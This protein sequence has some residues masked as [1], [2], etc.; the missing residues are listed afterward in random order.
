MKKNQNQINNLF[1]LIAL[2]VPK[3]SD[4]KS[5]YTSAIFSSVYLQSLDCN[6]LEFSV[7]MNSL[8]LRNVTLVFISEDTK[9]YKNQLMERNIDGNDYSLTLHS[10]NTEEFFCKSNLEYFFEKKKETNFETFFA[11][12]NLH[13]G[14]ICTYFIANGIQIS[15]GSNSKKHLISPLQHRL[16]LFLICAFGSESYAIINDSFHKP[17]QEESKKNFDSSTKFTK[18][19][20]ID[21]ARANEK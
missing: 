16:S 9:E 17:Y 20:V 15:G 11:F 19:I 5:G 4:N 7:R 2:T 14:T 18:N 12:K 13:W 8:N 21:F 10:F 6:F 3:P 1:T